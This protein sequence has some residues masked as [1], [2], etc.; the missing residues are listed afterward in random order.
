LPAAGVLEKFS[1]ELEIAVDVRL[2]PAP[3]HTPAHA[4][5]EVG[6][7]GGLVFAVDA[8]LHPLQVEHP[9][10]GRGMD[11]D[12]DEAAATRNTLLER[13]A[14]R[15]HLIGASHWDV[16]VQRSQTTDATPP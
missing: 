7:S 6:A 9:S 8:F 16:V 15:G 4:A 5:V 2:V 14:R 3:G 10:W 1:G 12:P 13:A 11:L